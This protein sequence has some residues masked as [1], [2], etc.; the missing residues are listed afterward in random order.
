MNERPSEHLLQEEELRVVDKKEAFARRHGR[1]YS[2]DIDVVLVLSD[3]PGKK[4]RLLRIDHD[5]ILAGV[6]VVHEVAAA[7]IKEA[8]GELVEAHYI[9]QAAISIYGPH[10]VCD[11]IPAENVALR[12]TLQSESNRLPEE[13]IIII[14]RVRVDDGSR[15]AIRHTGDQLEGF[16]GEITDPLS[17]I[18]GVINMAVVGE[19]PNL[20]KT[21]LE[22]FGQ[23]LKARRGI[24]VYLSTYE[25]EVGYGLRKNVYNLL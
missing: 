23:D 2:P 1:F 24:G 5:I 17:P 13:K 3:E 22:K 8:W 25:H 21:I 20:S 12:K 11:G 18:Y 19:S 7:H 14:D 15:R 16:I 6:A 10:F 4:D 9:K